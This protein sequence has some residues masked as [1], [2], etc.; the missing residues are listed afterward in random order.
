MSLAGKS[1]DSAWPSKYKCKEVEES[2]CAKACGKNV[3]SSKFENGWAHLEPLVPE[4]KVF[5]LSDII[6][7]ED[8]EWTFDA[9]EDVDGGVLGLFKLGRDSFT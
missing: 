2:S 9:N 6:D 5:K 4:P 8:P 3:P 1:L 7:T